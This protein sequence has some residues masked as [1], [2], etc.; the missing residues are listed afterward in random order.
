MI[1]LP[2]DLQILRTA[3]WISSKAK[4]LERSQ[5]AEEERRPVAPTTKVGRNDPCPC[6]SGTKFKKCCGS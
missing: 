2:N 5:L 3:D 4:E 1:H 6:G